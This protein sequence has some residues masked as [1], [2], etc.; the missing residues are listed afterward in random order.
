MWRINVESITFSMSIIELGCWQA[1]S[2]LLKGLGYHISWWLGNLPGKHF[3][4]VQRLGQKACSFAYIS[5]IEH[6]GEGDDGERLV[7]SGEVKRWRLQLLY[8]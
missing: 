2:L 3:A 6:D 5:R 1:R 8:D 4:G 7:L